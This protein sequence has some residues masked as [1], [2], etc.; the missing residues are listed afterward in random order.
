MND[1][2]TYR[3]YAFKCIAPLKSL[4]GYDDLGLVYVSPSDQSEEIIEQEE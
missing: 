4:D 2:D 1:S 3:E